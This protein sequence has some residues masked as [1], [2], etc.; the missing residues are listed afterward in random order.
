MMITGNEENGMRGY[1][2]IGK[3]LA[4]YALFCSVLVGRATPKRIRL[5]K[6]VGSLSCP[7]CGN[8]RGL[9][10][11]DNSKNLYCGKCGQKL[12]WDDENNK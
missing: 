3:E 2:E 6:V 7:S 5:D 11:L 10:G 12:E 4:S 8:G 9:I 1:L